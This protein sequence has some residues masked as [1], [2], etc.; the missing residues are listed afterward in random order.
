MG[1]VN[2]GIILTH[3]FQINI[4]YTVSLVIKFQTVITLYSICN[5]TKNNFVF[6][7]LITQYQ[8]TDIKLYPLQ[9]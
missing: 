6:S 9:D 4:L 1:A 2:D 8:R 3:R 5:L 7:M